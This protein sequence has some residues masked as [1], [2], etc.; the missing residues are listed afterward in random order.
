MQA[1]SSILI[2]DD[3]VKTR[4]LVSAFLTY[5]GYNIACP[6]HNALFFDTIQ[7]QNVDIVVVEVTRSLYLLHIKQ[8]TEF[9]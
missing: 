9:G 3:N 4:D 5:Q 2:A 7:K 6:E 1:N 8:L